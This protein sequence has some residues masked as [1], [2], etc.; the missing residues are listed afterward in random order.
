MILRQ[1]ADA[2]LPA[3][4]EQQRDP[5]AT[6]M[7][8]FP[9]RDRATFDAHWRRIL[10]DPEVTTRTVEID[11]RVAGNVASFD[12]GGERLVGYWIDRGHWGRGVATSALAAFLD[13][14]RARP[15]RAHVA[16]DNTGSI[17]VLEKCGFVAVDSHRSPDDGVVEIVMELRR[18]GSLVTESTARR[19]S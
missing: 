15:L 12:A 10:A 7:A 11:G 19:S 16:D 13:I 2:D 14:E 1:V 17:R 4:F 9:A 8:G 18:D 5:E 3:F 6:R